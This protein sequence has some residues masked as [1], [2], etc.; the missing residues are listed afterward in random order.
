MSVKIIDTLKQKNNGA[1]PIVEAVDVAVTSAI[2]LPEALA[3]K[4]DAS[5]LAQ[6]EA[7]ISTKAN[8]SDVETATA[9][10]QGQINQIEISASAEAVV[11][12]EV[13]A[14]RVD[15]EGTEYPTLKD[16]IDATEAM[17][18]SI[19]TDVDTLK[20]FEVDPVFDDEY[21]GWYAKSDKTI[22]KNN[23]YGLS[24]PIELPIFAK[25]IKLKAKNNKTIN[26][27][28][29]TAF[30]ADTPTLSV[31]QLVKGVIL[32][33]NGTAEI[34]L[35]EH[36]KMYLYFSDNNAASGYTGPDSW[37]TE[38]DITI[39]DNEWY[40]D[41]TETLT[42]TEE[43][44]DSIKDGCV[45][46]VD[47][48]EDVTWT[49]GYAVFANGTIL[50]VNGYSYTD[51]I[52]LKKGD[53]IHL[54]S[55]DASGENVARVSKWTS[56]GTFISVLSLGTTTLTTYD[57][58]ATAA[59]EYIRLC[60]QNTNTFIAKVAGHEAGDS[61]E[62]YVERSIYDEIYADL[63]DLSMFSDIAACGDSYTSGTLFSDASTLQGE[64]EEISWGK[65]L[66]RLSGVSVSVYASGGADTKTFQTRASCL[67]KILSDPAKEL[68]IIGLAI[69]DYTTYG[70][71][72]G[73]INDIKEDYTQ[74]EDTYYGNYGKII[75]QIQAHAP[76]AKIV[77]VKCWLTYSPYVGMYNFSS[78]PIEEIAE[79]FGIQFIETKNDPFFASTFFKQSHVN[80]PIEAT[81][82]GMAKAVKR[83]VE[84]NIQSHYS[85]YR[86]YGF[87]SN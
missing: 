31:G 12:P 50:A 87:D 42:E 44:V 19:K 58:T 35:T 54:T 82:S 9:N 27:Y 38:V 1:F 3:A 51:L 76:K 6:T 64:F 33:N 37:E 18:D 66:E 25:K 62:S 60:K 24:N 41:I 13:A 61:L 74:N 79:H 57:Y 43:T 21:V 36:K 34:E 26:Q 5:A 63:V 70:G 40:D 83:L 49:N 23:A 39:G 29:L 4:A 77:L 10:L 14:A 68:Y 72:A 52:H 16:R 30:V 78:T 8:T 53:K 17:S 48:L 7:V 20:G 22:A 65:D 11:A 47:L 45:H 75:A 59:D 15:S 71:N 85:Y 73:S 86:D 56:G 81:Y 84:M 2:R 67:P 69:N 55:K 46:E 32:S 28:I 80:H